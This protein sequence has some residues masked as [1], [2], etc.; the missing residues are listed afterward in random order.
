MNCSAKILAT[1]IL[2]H[3]ALELSIWL[4][5]PLGRTSDTAKT[6]S[7]RPSRNVWLEIVDVLWEGP[8][9]C[10]RLHCMRWNVS[11][12]PGNVAPV[13]HWR[14]RDTSPTFTLRNAASAR[15]SI[16]SSVGIWL[17]ELATE[18]CVSSESSVHWP[19]GPEHRNNMKGS[20]VNAFHTRIC[21]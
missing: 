9:F 21:L 3:P 11:S 2:H 4:G 6:P 14:A 19:I 18:C 1:N 13:R 10:G 8:G 16:V 7:G 17:W 5:K 20:S 15:R 12:V